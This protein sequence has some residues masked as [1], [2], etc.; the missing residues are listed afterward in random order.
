MSDPTKTAEQ[1]EQ[2]IFPALL[3][4][5]KEVGASERAISKIGPDT[6][7]FELG[8]FD[9]VSLVAAVVKAEKKFGISVQTGDFD[10]VNFATM[11]AIAGLIQRYRTR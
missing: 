2:E 11:R 5:I 9:S 7:L 6:D 10:P 1:A 4:I 8:V 3:V